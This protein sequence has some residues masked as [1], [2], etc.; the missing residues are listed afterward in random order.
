MLM[1]NGKEVHL[2]NPLPDVNAYRLLALARPG[3]NVF[4]ATGEEERLNRTSV[5]LKRRIARTGPRAASRPQSNQRGIETRCRL[6]AC[7]SNH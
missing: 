7:T 6:S 3:V 5:G 1:L 4:L 2:D